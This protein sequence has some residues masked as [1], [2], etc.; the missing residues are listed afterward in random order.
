MINVNKEITMVKRSLKAANQR[1]RMLK[2][3]H[4]KVV[5][6]RI[7]FANKQMHELAES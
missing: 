5:W 2:K 6:R 4:S 1:K 3:S 7:N